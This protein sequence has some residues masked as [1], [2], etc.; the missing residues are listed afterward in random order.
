M[1]KCVKM[2]QRRQYVSKTVKLSQVKSNTSNCVKL[3]QMCPK[4]FKMRQNVSKWTHYVLNYVLN[5]VKLYQSMSKCVE[6][7][8]MRQNLSKCVKLCQSLS[9]CVEL[10]QMRQNRSKRSEEHTSEPPVTQ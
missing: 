2:C 3:C 6:L 5:C 8:Q 4:P 10:C 7:C 9:K 1:S